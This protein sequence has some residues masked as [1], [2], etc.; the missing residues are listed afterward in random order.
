MCEHDAAITALGE[1]LTVAERQESRGRSPEDGGLRR[2]WC[3]ALARWSCLRHLGEQRDGLGSTAYTAPD[4]TEAARAHRRR[5]LAALAWPEAAGT[6]PEQREAL[7]LAVRHGLSA[8]EVGAVLA[9][10][11]EA[12]SSLLAGAACEVERT[13]AALTV[14]EWG[15]CSAV[16]R[17][18]GEDRALLGTA[19]HQ[20]LVRHIDECADCR[21]TAERA[22]AGVSWPGTA[23][24]TAALTVLEAPRPAV[25]AAVMAARRARFL[26]SPRFDKSGFPLDIRERTARRERLRSKAV[27]TTVVATVVA[28]PVLALWAAYRGA[29][30]TGEPGDG[31]VS[32][33]E[34]DK[35][36]DSDSLPYENAGRPGSASPHGRGDGVSVKVDGSSGE[37]KGGDRQPGGARLTVEARSAGQD[38]VLT[39]TA[40]RQAVRWSVVADA[41]WLRLSRSAGELGPGERATVRV[42]VVDGLE[43]A[44]A[45]AAHLRVAPG[46][47]VVTLRGRGVGSSSAP[48]PPSSPSPPAESEPTPSSPPSQKPPPSDGP[49]SPPPPGDDEPSS[50][51]P[52]D[53][54]SPTP[55]LSQ[56]APARG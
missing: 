42:S 47:A 1:A 36:S 49:S 17:L 44:G 38:T 4:L 55:T 54:P 32:A 6:A 20:E 23:P 24:V 8:R 37:R 50:P 46:G 10:S 5:E 12:A 27:T 30:T 40:G 45:W 41:S 39:L 21:R 3:Y 18:A 19:L 53:P 15:G 16:S 9:R 14:V 48:A 13:R 35:G 52:S 34:R 11:P 26:H 43:P 7:E 33:A 56:P 51:P 25:Q 2:P 31:P 22:M 29:P 28:A